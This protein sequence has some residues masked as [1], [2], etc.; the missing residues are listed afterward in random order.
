[1]LHQARRRPSAAERKVVAVG[2]NDD[3]GTSGRLR[4]AVAEAKDIHRRFSE[5][6]PLLLDRDA[7]RAKV[8]AGI[9]EATWS[10]FACHAAAGDDPADG[11]LVLADGPLPVK[12][13]MLQELGQPYLAFLSACTTAFGGAALLDESIHMASAFQVAGYR[14]AIGTLWPVADVIAPAF[15]QLVHNGL[16]AGSEPSAALH[17]ATRKM[18]DLYP[19]RPDLWAAHIHFGP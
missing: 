14:H 1:M 15:A 2:I 11:C 17:E 12:E 3:T 8:L 19:N 6:S 5:G 4:Y 18:R 13:I 7:T 16:E 9:S 10:H